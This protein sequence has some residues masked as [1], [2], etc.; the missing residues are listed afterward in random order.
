MAVINLTEKCIIGIKTEMEKHALLMLLQNNELGCVKI[1]NNYIYLYSDSIGRPDVNNGI[2]RVYLRYTNDDLKLIEEEALVDIRDVA[3]QL[4]DVEL[5]NNEYGEFS[6]MDWNQEIV[7]VSTLS[8]KSAIKFKLNEVPNLS[9]LNT[10]VFGSAYPEIE[11]IGYNKDGLF[12]ARIISKNE[13][14]ALFVNTEDP[15]DSYATEV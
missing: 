4:D 9:C 3:R 14:I 7:V 2:T 11:N 10:E 12:Q 5:S 15:L 8:G 13:K 6:Y 1:W